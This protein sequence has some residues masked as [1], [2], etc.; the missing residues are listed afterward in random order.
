M[1]SEVAELPVIEIASLHMVKRV[2]PKPVAGV[3]KDFQ[4]H[5][6]RLGRVLQ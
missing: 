3:G 6:V 5:P 4:Q 2:F 1:T